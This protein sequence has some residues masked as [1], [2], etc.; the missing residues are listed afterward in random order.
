VEIINK[1]IL[2]TDATIAAQLREIGADQTKIGSNQVKVLRGISANQAK[3]A[4]RLDQVAEKLSKIDANQAE[5]AEKLSKMDANQAEVAKTLSQVAEKLSKM[6]ANQAEVAE[7]L[8]KMDANQAEVA[9]KL[10]KMDANQAEVAEKLSKMDANQAEVAKTLSQVAEK[11]SKMDANQAEK[12]SKMDANQAE[13]A[14]T[15]SQVA[16]KLSKMDANQAEKLSKMDANLEQLVKLNGPA[17][18]AGS[19]ANGEHSLLFC[20]A[21]GPCSKWMAPSANMAFRNEAT[22]LIKD[23]LSL[24]HRQYD[25]GCVDEKRY[26]QPPSKEL[27]QSLMDLYFSDNQVRMQP[28]REYIGTVCDCNDLPLTFRGRCDAVILCDSTNFG[29]LCWEVKN[30]AEKLNNGFIAQVGTQMAGELDAIYNFYRK[31]APKLA[32]VLTNGREFVFLLA[33]FEED[34]Y[35]WRCSKVIVEASMIAEMIE[36]CFSIASSLLEFLGDDTSFKD[37]KGDGAD[38]GSDGEVAGEARGGIGALFGR[39][40]RSTT[41]AFG[42]GAET[43]KSSDIKGSKNGGGRQK[44]NRW[45]A[46]LTVANVELFNRLLGKWR[47]RLEES[48]EDYY[49]C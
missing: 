27:L 26:V 25:E 16:E 30:L 41:R 32:G 24:M 22:E 7:K 18:V 12:L 47:P 35:T 45:L 23:H 3:V 48:E 36:G 28:E 14:K 49:C 15:L 13:V 20:F 5:V 9:E 34:R 4:K 42:H 44:S 1:I 17:S 10:S 43:K 29:V 46:P 37:D 6:D 21:G 8:S 19:A 40:T 39:I 33:S 11:L 38:D 2:P 31:K